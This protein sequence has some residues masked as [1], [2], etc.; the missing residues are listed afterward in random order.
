MKIVTV[1][2]AHKPYEMPVDKMY[3]PLQVGAFGKEDIGYK[4]DDEGENISKKNPYYSELT[5]L[6]WAWKNLDADYIGLSHYRRHFTKKSKIYRRNHPLTECVLTL[7][8]ANELLKNNDI[9]LPR[10]RKYYIESLYSHYAHTLD[11]SHLDIA[12]E[13]ISNVYPEYL[14]A[15]DKIYKQTWGY[16]WNMTIMSKENIDNYCSWIFDILLRMEE[17]I[18]TTKMRAFEAR[19]F[20]RVSEI[21]FNVWLEKNKS[22]MARIAEVPVFSMEPV[23]WVKKIAAFLAAKFLKKHY[24]ESF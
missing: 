15:A 14:E 16:M 9:I 23:P 6:Y 3:L 17:K 4:R 1:V 11:G 7:E 22:Q 5:G 2:A 8:E 13:I 12:R 18:D 24:G 20:G 19:L 10:K 21:L